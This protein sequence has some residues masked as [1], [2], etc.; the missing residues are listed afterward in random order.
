MMKILNNTRSI[1]T[2]SLAGMLGVTAISC[3]PPVYHT[4]EVEPG[5][6]FT[7]GVGAVAYDYCFYGLGGG[8]C[9]QARGGRIDLMYRYA[10]GKRFIEQNHPTKTWNR[11]AIIGQAG[12]MI[13]HEG[14]GFIEMPE[15]SPVEIFPWGELGFEFEFL[16]N[17]S[18]STQFGL[19][20]PYIPTLT[21]LA[22]IPL[23]ERE[24]ATVGFKT[25][26]YVPYSVFLTLHPLERL[27]LSVQTN[28]VVLFYPGEWEVQAVLGIDII[29][30]KH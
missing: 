20:F 15:G 9:E 29:N 21:F 23:R 5:T 8:R 19:L 1:L 30:R 2:L 6:S 13:T 25:V 28:P 18:L 10:G 3:L 27:H 11:L 14:F 22:G 16:E 12:A 7:V 26:S 24:I 4:A 17:P